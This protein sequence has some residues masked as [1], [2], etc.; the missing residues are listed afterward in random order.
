MYTIQNRVEDLDDQYVWVCPTMAHWET[1]YTHQKTSN[2]D[3]D[4]CVSELYMCVCV[5]EEQVYSLTMFHL[6]SDHSR[7][8]PLLIAPLEDLTL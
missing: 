7:S 2:E 5:S 3:L 8:I 4:L 6:H 1:L